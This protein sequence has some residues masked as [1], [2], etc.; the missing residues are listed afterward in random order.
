MENQNELIVRF[1]D[2]DKELKNPHTLTVIECINNKPHEIKFDSLGKSMEY[3]VNFYL[4]HVA[5]INLYKDKK[6]FRNCKVNIFFD[7]PFEEETK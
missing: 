4:K 3:I 6:P 2:G 5:A 7:K 1:H